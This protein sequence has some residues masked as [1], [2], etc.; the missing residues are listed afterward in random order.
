V[1]SPAPK[2][3]RKPLR[4]PQT[5]QTTATPQRKPTARE[6]A[7]RVMR[8]VFEP[9]YYGTRAA[10]EY[11]ATHAE[12]DARSRAFATE[13]AYG[14]IKMRRLLDWWLQPYLLERANT[15]PK[16]I[17]EIV[18]MG[19]YQ[20]RVMDGVETYAAVSESVGLAKR[21]GH[22]GTAG[23][24]N[25][26]L[27]RMSE[28]EAPQP[29]RADFATDDDYLG[30]RY[31][32][33]TWLV[34]Q[35]RERFGDARIEP[36][37]AGANAPAPVGLRIDLRL[38]TPQ[39]IVDELA[40]A[41]IPA[42]VSPFACDAVVLEGTASTVRLDELLGARASLHGEAALFPVDILDPQPGET[43]LDLCSGRGNK[44]RQIL[45]RTNDT[46]AIETVELDAR[47]AADLAAS[48]RAE[49]AQSVVV[50]ER[51]A[52]FVDD[53]ATLV[54]RALVDAPCSGIG[55]VGRQPE[56]RWRKSPE[57]GERLALV[58]IDILHAAALRI[59]PGGSL[60]YSVCSTDAREGDDVVSAF[61]GAHPSF[62]R[63]P[64][65]DRYAP[66]LTPLGD[67]LVPPG[68]DGRDGFFVARLA[69]A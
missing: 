32:Y 38:A 12:L 64:M 20:L 3:K 30:T 58:Q 44:T 68:I 54:D 18:R 2:T 69:R 4:G 1:R 21:F 49:G 61:L 33:P 48:L 57:D 14:T 29:A 22:R 35:F 24:V 13:L 56:A 47:K 17:R 50:F 23:I 53:E 26:V 5:P 10:I 8:D 59:R 28:V 51:D 9:P 67:V 66:F 34:T 43:I 63:A 62:A 65:P 11:R 52:A 46:G 7:L 55:I 40:A 31:S 25:A 37:L 19:A 36:I 16:T 15:I 45:A 27:R 39:A 60:V 6:V 41:E 42:H